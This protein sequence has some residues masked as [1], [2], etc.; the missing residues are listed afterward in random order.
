MR[1]VR[2]RIA[3]AAAPAIVVSTLRAVLRERGSTEYAVVD[4]GHDMAAAGHPG[5]VAWTVIFGN[6]AGGAK[7]LAHDLAAAVDIPLRLAVVGADGGSSEI[8][9]RDMRSLLADDVAELADAFTASLR[10]LSETTRDRVEADSLP[11][12]T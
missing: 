9:L 12:S 6:P 7:L 8:V 4:H 11:A 10:T 3:V 2:E 5:L 1:D